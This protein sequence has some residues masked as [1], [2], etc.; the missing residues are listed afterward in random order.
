M[1]YVTFSLRT[2][3]LQSALPVAI[4]SS[5]AFVNTANAAE[6]IE[7]VVV[8]AQKTEQNAQRV[9]I[10]LTAFTAADLAKKNITSV[11]QL[12][13]SAPNVTFD[14]GVPFGAS[15]DV[16]AAYIRG[17][18][19]NDFA[20]NQDPGVGVY[21]DGVYLARSVGANQSLL[22]VERIEVLKGP[23]G[24]LFGRN[25]IG[26]AVSIIT[27]D[28]GDTFAYRAQV[29]GGSYSRLDVAGTVDIPLS[30]SLHTS[31]SFSENSQDGYLKRIPFPTTGPLFD[32]AAAASGLY[33]S[34]AQSAAIF[35]PG[36]PAG[37]CF[38]AASCPTIV[39]PTTAGIQA[40]YTTHGRE[41]GNNDWHV[42]GK[43]VWTASDD[44]KFTVSGDY[45]NSDGQG[46]ATKPLAI[47]TNY[48]PPGA[49]PTLGN[50]YNTCIGS[51]SGFL[52]FLS[53]IPGVPNFPVLCGQRGTPGSTYAPS[54]AAF[55][56]QVAGTLG[57]AN[58]DGNPNN[59]RLAYGPWFVTSSPDTSYSTGPTFSQLKNYGAALVI[60]WNV[61]E[62]MHLKSTTAY[63][64]LQFTAG[65]DGDGS[66]LN[67]HELSFHET[68][69]EFS[70]ELQLTGTA[71]DGKLDYVLGAYYFHEAGGI[72]DFVTFPGL[73]LQVDGPNFLDT[74][75]YAG[76]FHGDYHVTDKLTLTVGGRYTKE[77][78]TFIGEQSD[79]NAL[80]YK[81]TPLT[82]DVGP[83]GGPP[84][85]IPL[86]C[87]NSSGIGDPITN[88]CR[89][90]MGFPDPNNPLTFYPPGQHKLDFDNFAP[91]VGAEYQFTGDIMAFIKYS[92][93]FKTGSWTTR[94]S[95]PHPTYDP[96]LHFNPEKAKSYE[97]GLKTQFDDDRMRLNLTGFYTKYDGIQIN[98]QIGISP[99]ILNAGNATIYGG[100][101]EYQALLT[102][103]FSVNA[104]VGYQNASYDKVTPGAGSNGILI[105]TATPLPKTPEWKLNISPE[106][107]VPL[108]NDATLRF[109]LDYTFTS[110]MTN[111]VTGTPELNRPDVSMLNAS[112]TYTPPAGNWEVSVGG[113]NL[114]D[115]R[116]IVTGVNQGGIQVI[117]GSYNAPREWMA[118]L[119]I[120]S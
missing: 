66:P 15:T 89:I 98:F 78:K 1:A 40:G 63:R 74:T 5:I 33:M 47:N 73:L 110:S 19:Q 3:L 44:L 38:G 17:I 48:L 35:G 105:T 106:Y 58:F 72:H 85:I 50:A 7:T 92:E 111:D 32:Q 20:F 55:A 27:R 13:D 53:T 115:E 86:N 96:S 102:D 8:T 118:T 83:P 31:L 80:V 62:N 104:S 103:N 64:G 25:T 77:H 26:G 2:H 117:Y 30:D 61:A 112:V 28:P 108:D 10:A 116:Y 24:T 46:I 97:A 45:S 29:T 56:N 12:S 52:A 95:S 54:G 39:D 91:S 23:Q 79:P 41:G 36:S 22:D 101:L 90:A 84:V 94:L 119:R 9:P 120:H 4:L 99:T 21:V 51:P 60:D 109:N 68:Q 88:A 67:I 114:T 37:D 18:G 70:Q 75:S 82:I 34:P 14:A 43:A 76:Y 57:G 11:A 107:R 71:F 49:N 65:E 16:L 113:T 42:R 69:H 81:I 59:N 100:E 6:T 87:Y 93:G